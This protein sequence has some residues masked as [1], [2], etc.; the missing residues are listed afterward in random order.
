MV[1]VNADPMTDAFL[2]MDAIVA[3]PRDIYL[4][5]SIP[6]PGAVLEQL[7]TILAGVVHC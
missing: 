1:N 2:A 4:S 5:A 7:L 6:M 3:D